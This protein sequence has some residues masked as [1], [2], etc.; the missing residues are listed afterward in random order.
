M[1]APIQPLLITVGVLIAADTVT[2]IMAAKK[3]GEKITSAGL[4][5]SIVK[6][7]V[8]QTVL[9]T[10]FLMEKYLLQD[11]GI[12]ILKLISGVIGLTEF[13]SLLENTETLTG[14]DL[15]KLKKLLGSKNDTKN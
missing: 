15:L 13:I 3:R 11:T 7:F 10:G 6:M 2:G 12:P 4:G 9:I 1:F 8:Y 5:R 14:V